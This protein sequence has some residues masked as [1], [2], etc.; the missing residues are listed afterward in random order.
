[1]TRI[2]V[3][4]P[5]FLLI[6]F[7]PIH[8]VAGSVTAGSVNGTTGSTSL[9]PLILMD[10]DPM[11]RLDLTLS[12]DPKICTAVDVLPGDFT[13][14]TTLTSAL[15]RGEVRAALVSPDGIG[16]DGVLIWVRFRALASEG[17]SNIQVLSARSTVPLERIDGVLTIIPGIA[18]SRTAE[19][20]QRVT[21]EM[22]GSAARILGDT[23]SLSDGDM[24]ILIRTEGIG[25]TSRIASG[26][27]HNVT[28][29][30]PKTRVT[31]P[32]GT[33]M[34]LFALTFPEYPSE[35]SL[36]LDLSPAPS[37]AFH[38]AIRQATNA[39][40]LNLTAVSFVA[41]PTLHGVSSSGPVMFSFTL[42]HGFAPH[43]NETYRLAVREAAGSVSLLSPSFTVSDD[44]DLRVEAQ[45]SRFPS[46]LALLTVKESPR[47]AVVTTTYKSGSILS[48]GA[49][50]PGRK[51]LGGN[52]HDVLPGRNRG[53]G[54]FLRA[55]EKRRVTSPKNGK[56]S[57]SCISFLP[58]Q[59]GLRSAHLPI[60]RYRLSVSI[61]NKKDQVSPPAAAV[62]VPIRA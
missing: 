2:W 31:L 6:L 12:Y 43:T 22:Q 14:N 29:T 40:R 32:S 27:V 25:A 62:P 23:I 8:A 17:S 1:M 37:S 5:F 35:G 3:V 57:S 56:E 28:M 60:N 59:T 61:F 26:L 58:I 47:A 16:G 7:L 13:V 46:E 51:Y 38:N 44:G 21:V 42:P 34:G 41:R 20:R 18:F 4:A 36:L 53:G 50:S 24:Q 39:S 15:D 19:G 9:V 54:S 55:P 49:E 11:Y 48:T 52:D 10:A 45:V 33:V 30:S